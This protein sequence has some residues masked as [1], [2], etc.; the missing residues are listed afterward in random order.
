MC[1]PFLAALLT[2][3]IV[4]LLVCLFITNKRSPVNFCTGRRIFT[5]ATGN[6]VYENNIPSMYNVGSEPSTPPPT[7]QQEYVP[8][9]LTAEGQNHPE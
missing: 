1:F 6:T 7:G 8:T 2:F 3:I 5:L 4:Y 9:A